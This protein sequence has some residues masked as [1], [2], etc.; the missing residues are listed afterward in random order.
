MWQSQ[1][2]SGEEKRSK[3]EGGALSK[4]IITVGAVGLKMGVVGWLAKMA[5]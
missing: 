5:G 3:N 4:T 1:R 2:Q